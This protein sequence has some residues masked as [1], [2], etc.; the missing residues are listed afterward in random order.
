VAALLV[1]AALSA[2]GSSGAQ[3]TATQS[4]VPIT[5]TTTTPV[6]TS[7]VPAPTRTAYLGPD[8]VPIETGSFL[9]PATTTRLGMIVDG[10][11]CQS[12]AQLAYTAYSHLQ[13]YV[14]GRSVALPGGIGLVGVKTKATS[15]GLVFSPKTCMYWLHTLAAD[16]IIQVQSPVRRAYTLGVLF[17]IWD[18]PLSS[19]QVATAH[20]HVIATVNGR[21]W[22]GDPSAIPLRERESIQIAVGTPVPPYAAVDWVGTKL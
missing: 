21:R 16:G 4:T 22:P 13:V 20:G 5:F 12:I 8:N 9:A 17:K 2:C 14:D 18:Q 7:T 11:Q 15:H 6:P 3:P 10:V 1:S 19:D